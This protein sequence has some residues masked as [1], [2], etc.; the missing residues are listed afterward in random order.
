MTGPRGTET[1]EVLV[2]GDL[3]VDV[4]AVMSAPLARDSD[5]PST[6]TTHG[7]G[8]AA[9]VAAW[10]AA[11]GVRTTFVGCVG[12]DPFGREGLARLAGTGVDVSRV[13]VDPARTTGTC[14]VLVEPSGERSMLPDPGA[15][16]ALV[17]GDLPASLF[18]PGRHLHLSGYTLLREGSRAAGLAALTRA[19]EVRMTVSVDPSSA[20]L[21]RDAGTDRFL[22]WTRGV[23]VL[24]PNSDE[25]MVL[26]GA[27]DAKAAA[28]ELSSSYDE[29][30]VTL[31][32][33]GALW[34]RGFITATA[35]AERSAEVVDTTGAGD[36]FAAGFLATWLLHPE[37]ETALA[38]GNRLAAR[39]I[40]QVGA[41]P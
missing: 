20:A 2:V 6:V 25:A 7:G 32:R 38:A 28:A 33:E 9:N 36:A 17:A 35:P 1:L 11:L 30:V 29:V 24:L 27:P 14:L 31:G 40:E 15:N 4:L 41:R 37:P 3:M 8:S 22:G 18:R 16:D 5:T 12:D 26:A 10:L 23:Q 34:Q 13:A 21:L 19:L 39:A